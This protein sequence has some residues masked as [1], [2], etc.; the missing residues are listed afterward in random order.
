MG[1]AFDAIP[2]RVLAYTADV[3]GSLTGI[4]A[5]ALMSYYQTTPHLWFL[6]IVLVL[7]RFVRHWT[8]IQVLSAV[9][10][11]F[12]IALSAYGVGLEERVFWSPYYKVTY[13]DYT[14]AIDTNNIAHQ[15]MIDVAQGRGG[16]SDAASSQSR[17]RRRAVR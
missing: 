4:A 12:V 17:C 1:R 10:I 9:G 14:R 11:I 8:G 6:I 7:I 13:K 2:N 5:F 16:V 15:E 3:L